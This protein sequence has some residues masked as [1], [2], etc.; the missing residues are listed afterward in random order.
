MERLYIVYTIH[1][2]QHEN[3]KHKKAGGAILISEKSL[4]DKYTSYK[5]EYFIMIKG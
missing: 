2:I 4:Q 5:E 3:R 1:A